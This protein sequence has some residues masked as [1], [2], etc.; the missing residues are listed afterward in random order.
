LSGRVSGFKLVSSLAL[1]DARVPLSIE[2]L[3]G[4]NVVLNE[5]A[6]SVF[7]GDVVRIEEFTVFQPRVGDV[8]D[9]ERLAGPNQIRPLVHVLVRER[10]GEIGL[11]CG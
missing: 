6:L 2:R 3:D 8:R 4:Q 1:I 9:S 11:R 10:N 7:I 5:E